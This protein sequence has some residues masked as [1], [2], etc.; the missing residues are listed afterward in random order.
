MISLERTDAT[1][2]QFI[3][4]VVHL[5]KELAIRDGDDHAFYSQFN[6]VDQINH[7]ILVF[8]DGAAVACGAIKAYDSNT[9][10]IKRM[11]TNPQHRGLG[12]ATRILKEL[13]KW[14]S[15]L[16]YIKCILE[17]GIHQPEAIALYKKSGYKI[18]PNYGQ[19][20]KVVTSLCFEKE[21][22]PITR[23]NHNR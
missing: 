9:M 7:V 6:T 4:L 20:K 1:D 10:E 17:T 12:M 14:A 23:V 22:I 21:L 16:M 5:D 3:E 2:S 8:H 19:Y 18:I 13:E 15:E 11:Y